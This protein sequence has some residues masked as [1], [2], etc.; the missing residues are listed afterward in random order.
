M[1]AVED[2][3]PL[4]RV[5]VRQLTELG[6]RVLE[7]SNA[8]AAIDVMEHENIDLLFSDIVMPGGINGVELAGQVQQRWPKIR[9]VL[10]S[11]F[12]E[13]S[14]DASNRSLAPGTRLLTK[15]YRKVDLAAAVRAALDA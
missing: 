8:A 5:V 11:G 10:T 6:Y 3:A 7:A 15:P 14:L 9:T 12:P 2:D 13:T 1:L 4:R